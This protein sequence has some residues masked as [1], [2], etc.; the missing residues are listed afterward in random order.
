MPQE[1]WG[2]RF[3]RAQLSILGAMVKSHGSWR[4]ED[5]ERL[6]I[7]KLGHL[8]KDTKI[9]GPDEIYLFSLPV[10]DSVITDIFL[11]ASLKDVV[12]KIMQMWAATVKLVLVLGPPRR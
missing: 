11:R 8:V 10:K 4:Y 9:T 12:L 3:G 7:P 5:N 2:P 1:D 6:P